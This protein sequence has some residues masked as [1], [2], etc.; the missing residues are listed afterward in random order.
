MLSA[1]EEGDLFDSVKSYKLE[2]CNLFKFVYQTFHY[3]QNKKCTAI[4]AMLLIC[5][6]LPYNNLNPIVLRHIHSNALLKY[7][8]YILCLQENFVNYFP[9]EIKRNR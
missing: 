4:L 3:L 1:F 9:L 6:R 8:I 7:D 5:N 2:I